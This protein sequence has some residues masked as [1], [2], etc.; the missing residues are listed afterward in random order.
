MKFSAPFVAV[1]L[2]LLVAANPVQVVKR[3]AVTV[4]VSS[5]PSLTNPPPQHR[6]PLPSIPFLKLPTYLFVI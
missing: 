1:F 6:L 5:L 2:G 4:Q 3:D